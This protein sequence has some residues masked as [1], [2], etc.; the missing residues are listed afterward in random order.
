[1]GVFYTPMQVHGNARACAFHHLA[2][3]GQ[4]QRFHIRKLDVALRGLAEDRFQRFAMLA[5][6]ASYCSGFANGCPKCRS[7]PRTI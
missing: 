1:M 4:H 3:Q 6:N 2:T 7:T 5:V